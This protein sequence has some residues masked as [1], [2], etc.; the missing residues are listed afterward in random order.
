MKLLTNS[1][2]QLILDGSKTR[3]G[4]VYND[5]YTVIERETIT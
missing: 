5:K 3:I 2:C 4:I 1:K